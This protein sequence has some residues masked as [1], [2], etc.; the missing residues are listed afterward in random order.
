LKETNENEV[1]SGKYC[2]VAV[3]FL[4]RA[5]AI[6]AK[7]FLGKSHLAVMEV[8]VIVHFAASVYIYIY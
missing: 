3:S 2:W 1:G 8:G 7:A 4:L 6:I 5:Y